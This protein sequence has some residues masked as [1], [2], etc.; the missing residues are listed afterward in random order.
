MSTEC[1]EVKTPS[2]YFIFFKTKFEDL[3]YFSL[4]KKWVFDPRK[5]HQ[6]ESLDQAMDCYDSIMMEARNNDKTISAGSLFLSSIDGNNEVSK[7]CRD[8]ARIDL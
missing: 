7:L 5:A 6:F 1:G 4:E 8:D 3:Y 2:K